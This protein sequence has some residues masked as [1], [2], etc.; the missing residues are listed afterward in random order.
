MSTRKYFGTDGIRGRANTEPMTA[1]TA[2]RVA[3]AA[4]FYFKREVH[5]HR[6]KVV[7]GKD[8]RLSGYMLEQAMTAGF[9]SMGMDVTLVG[10]M[11]TPAIAQLTRSLRADLG[12]MISASHNPFQDNGIKLFGMDGFKLSDAVEMEIERLIDSDLSPHLAGPEDI[13]R[14]KRV[15]EEGGRYVE[16]V[17]N[18]FPKNA[19]LHGMKIVLDCANGAA[20]KVAPKILWELG[21]EVIALGVDPNGKNIN[22]NCGATDTVAM[23]DAVLIHGAHLGIALDGDADRLIMCDEKACR[24]DGDQVMAAI[25]THWHASGRLTGNG[26]VMTVMSNMGLEKYI[27]GLGLDFIRAANGDRY[28]MEKM[29][30]GGYNVGGEQ[31]G[32][33]ITLDYGTTGD[34]LMAALQV[35]AAVQQSGKPA[36]EVLNVFTPS[37]QILKNFRFTGANPLETPQ[38]KEYLSRVTAEIDG[39]GRILVRKSGT[40]SLIRVMAEGDDAAEVQRVV[41]G[42]C[43]E[44]GKVAA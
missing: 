31:T 42:I 22:R 10:P 30:A 6:P 5:N 19:T 36:S 33:F 18:T 11:P 9:L 38:I 21:A 7:I 37:P 34:G 14:A 2:L 26:V 43:G 1:M 28:V 4:A 16:F 29:L 44:L 20:Y 25:A 13:G 24:I 8:T 40:E 15:D 35:L 17:K 32:H 39:K 12:V 3:Q 41:D 23:Q 27:R